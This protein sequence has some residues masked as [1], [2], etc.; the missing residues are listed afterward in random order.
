MERQTYDQRKLTVEIFLKP[1]TDLPPEQYAATTKEIQESLESL[2]EIASAR[3][4]L[5]VQSP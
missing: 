2:E 3:I 5:D 1:Q 4:F